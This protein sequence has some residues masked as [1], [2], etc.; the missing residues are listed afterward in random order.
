MRVISGTAK[1]TVLYS[2]EGNAT[3]PTL[4][5]V[6][7]A[8]FNILQMEIPNAE[9][10]DLFAGSGALG[11]EAL[12]RGAKRAV[13]CDR[14]RNAINIINKNLEKTHFTKKAILLGEDYKVALDSLKERFQFDIIFLDP[15]Y[16]KDFVAQAVEKILEFELLKQDGMIMIETD[17]E[18]R[19]L[20]EIKDLNVIVRDLRKYGRV[21][22]I[23]L[24]SKEG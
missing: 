20:E 18:E 21:H 24:G 2:L 15:P 14:S 11:I 10:L 8:I 17:E 9:V 13:L 5:R 22:L 1:G 16:A 19:I 4:D 7:E 6:K 3:R 12:S 23:F